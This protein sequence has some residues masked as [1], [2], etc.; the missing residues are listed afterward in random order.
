MKKIFFILMLAVS[1]Q[2]LESCRSNRITPE[3]AAQ[4]NLRRGSHL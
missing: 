3:R 2:F 4:G 1:I